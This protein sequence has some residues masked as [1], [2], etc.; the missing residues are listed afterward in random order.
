MDIKSI[1]LLLLHEKQLILS[2]SLNFLQKLSFVISWITCW[3]FFFF[4]QTS[5]TL[6]IKTIVSFAEMNSYLFLT[7][8]NQVY[9]HNFLEIFNTLL[10]LLPLP[11]LHL[12]QKFLYINFQG[13]PTNDKLLQITP[14]HFLDYLFC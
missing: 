13:I 7:H 11:I 8:I 14:H 9:F 10:S 6:R 2:L 1:L 5:L 12:L 4:L 3:F